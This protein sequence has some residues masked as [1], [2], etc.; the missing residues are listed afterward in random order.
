MAA[1]S[2]F[3]SARLYPPELHNLAAQ[4][5]DEIIQ[6]LDKGTMVDVERPSTSFLG[7]L[8]GKK[9]VVSELRPIQVRLDKWAVWSLLTL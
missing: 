9:E 1:S 5:A 3:P 2:H 7:K 6:A 8:L 4:I